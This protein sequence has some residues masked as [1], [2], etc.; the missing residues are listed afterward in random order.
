MDHLAALA[1]L[2]P[3]T[4]INAA[5]VDPGDKSPDHKAALAVLEA[6][7]TGACTW[8][9]GQVKAAPALADLRIVYVD[10]LP[11]RAGAVQRKMVQL[12]PLVLMVEDQF[13]PFGLSKRPGAADDD[14]GRDEE[15]AHGGG[16]FKVLKGLAHCSGSLCGAAAVAGI[17]AYLV[18]HGTWK[19][20]L[21]RGTGQTVARRGSVEFM[22]ALGGPGGPI[23]KTHDRAAA[24]A[25]ALVGLGV[26]DVQ[27]Q[28]GPG[29]PD[30][31]AWLAA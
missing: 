28:L 15:A 14:Q 18:A 27:A 4:R 16:R 20:V 30:L 5:G 25:I 31:G 22:R 19:A 17:P 2:P 23:T 8:T 12:A 26:V 29:N 1:A 13:W 10:E 11:W 24:V 7:V 21:G 3:G 9:R 6:T